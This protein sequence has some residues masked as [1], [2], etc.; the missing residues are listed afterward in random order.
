MLKYRKCDGEI[1]RVIVTSATSGIRA[2]TFSW[3]CR[4][5]AYRGG[6]RAVNELALRE[7]LRHLARSYIRNR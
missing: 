7:G 3:R 5:K 1:V 4:D 2:T 6:R